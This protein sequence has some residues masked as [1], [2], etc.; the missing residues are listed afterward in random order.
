MAGRQ[1]HVRK[2]GPYDGMHACM[3]AHER[4]D[5]PPAHLHVGPPACRPS[6]P[7]LDAC[8]H[9]L[10]CMRSPP[11]IASRP[12]R[13]CPRMKVP[14]THLLVLCPDH[15]VDLADKQLEIEVV[16]QGG[17]VEALDGDLGARAVFG[18]HPAELDA[19]ESPESLKQFVA[20]SRYSQLK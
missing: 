7:S 10:T 8:M 2:A 13:V 4:G 20:V 1:G 11:S 18:R 19:T 5:S 17:R 9:T 6:L 15:D 16:L 12:L 14:R 3:Q